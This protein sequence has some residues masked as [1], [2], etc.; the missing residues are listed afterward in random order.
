V[1]TSASFA[2]AFFEEWSQARPTIFVRSSSRSR[3]VK[4][5]ANFLELLRMTAFEMHL[6][7][8]LLFKDSS[9][10]LKG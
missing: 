1:L 2:F 8:V 4:Q 3:A 7:R 10:D 5:F 6:Q 9:E